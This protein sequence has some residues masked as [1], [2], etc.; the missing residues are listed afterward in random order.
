MS[1]YLDD[2][3]IVQEEKL[4]KFRDRVKD[5]CTDKHNDYQLLRWLRARDFD[6]DKSEK[7]FRNDVKWRKDNKC[8]TIL[9][10]WKPPEVIQKY[11]TGGLAGFDK[12]GC[13]VWIDPYGHIDIRGLTRSVK[14]SDV[15]RYGIYL[16]ETIF[17]YFASQTE[18][19]GKTIDQVTL[20]FDLDKLGTK[21]MYRPG[22]D[23]L[24]EV[25][26]MFEDH[27]PETLKFAYVINAPRLFP[28]AFR[29]IKPFLS[30][31]TRNRIHILGGNFKKELLNL[32]SPEELPVHWGGDR[33][34]KNG[35]P[36]CSTDISFGGDVPEECYLSASTVSIS[37]D[38]LELDV[39]R[40]STQKLEYEVKKEG[41]L[42][43]WE[44]MTDGSD[45]GFGVFMKT[46]PGPQKSDEME[47]VVP[48]NRLN[49][50]IVPED[51]N[52]ECTKTGT[53][54]IRF[55]NS[56]SYVKAKKVKYNIQVLEADTMSDVSFHSAQDVTLM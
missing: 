30:E 24:I 43:K 3:S 47:V 53:Y 37:D 50:H 16:A 40:G 52:L 48:S 13:P 8:D 20:I 26:V 44:F 49:S 22:L 46:A 15:K 34:D 25:F 29:L 18:K 56:Y 35:D 54:V 39:G 6:L 17:S 27:Y 23:L 36:K 42:L 38:W 45:I 33:K 55:D 11:Y 32:M 28:V 7:M 5:V 21:H 31:H 51:G 10:T 9:D 14:S 1:G 4:K 19:L 2:L 12:E 41:C